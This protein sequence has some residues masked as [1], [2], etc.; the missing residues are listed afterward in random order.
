PNGARK[1]YK[2]SKQCHVRDK[3]CC[4]GRVF[5]KQLYRDR[6][7]AGYGAGT[8]S[9][10]HALL[11]STALHRCNR[12]FHMELALLYSV[13]SD[14]P[15]AVLYYDSDTAKSCFVIAD[16][17]AGRR[18]DCRPAAC[19]EKVM[20]QASLF[21]ERQE[22]LMK[23]AIIIG[24]GLGGL[25]AAVTLANAG[26]AVELYEKNSHLG[27]KLMP[28]R[29]GSHT[30]DFGPNTITMPEVFNAVI[31]QTGESAADYFELVPL[32]THTRNHFPDGAHLDF[33]SD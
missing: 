17:V 33:S 6:S 15:S 29:L 4:M 21:V 32:T 7:V 8:Y 2:V 24:G 16:A 11:H 13:H 12:N 27:G 20:E 10:L 26:M 9:F 22:L 3:P 14:L 28:V 5:E 31:E 18:D 1:C 23:K 30:F 25:S 19:N